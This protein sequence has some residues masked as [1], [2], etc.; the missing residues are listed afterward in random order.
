M[1]TQTAQRLFN[2]CS[3]GMYG[4]IEWATSITQVHDFVCRIKKPL[5]CNYL[6]VVALTKGRNEG[7]ESHE[8]DKQAKEM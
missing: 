3:H 6:T 4:V 5:G 1:F 2:V 8:E 7:E